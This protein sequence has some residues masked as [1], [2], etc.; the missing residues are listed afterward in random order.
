MQLNQQKIEP[1]ADAVDEAL[2][3]IRNNPQYT[4]Y[5]ERFDAFNEQEDSEDRV[6]FLT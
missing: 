5:G 3:F 4:V 1:F 2:E 6:R